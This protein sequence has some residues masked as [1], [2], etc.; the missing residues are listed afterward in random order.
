MTEATE[1]TSAP[2]ITVSK[3]QAVVTS[4]KPSKYAD[5]RLAKKKKRRAAHRATIKRS[6]ANG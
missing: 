6:N 5:A 3:P 2:E 4:R 1:S